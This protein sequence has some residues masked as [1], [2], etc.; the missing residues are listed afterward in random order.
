MP[1]ASNQTHK[2]GNKG[3]DW[4][5]IM[6]LLSYLCNDLWTEQLV[7][8]FVPYAVSYNYTVVTDI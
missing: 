4:S 1:V 6:M 8:K 3:H 2:L 7:V 5:L